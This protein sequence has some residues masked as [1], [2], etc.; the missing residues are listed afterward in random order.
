MRSG[1]SGTN[2]RPPFEI[3]YVVA[4]AGSTADNSWYSQ[5]DPDT[6]SNSDY[7]N[8]ISDMEPSVEMEIGGD[9]VEIYTFNSG[10]SALDQNTF[11]STYAP[12][13]TATLD[14]TY[15][16]GRKVKFSINVSSET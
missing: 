9:W 6:S 5:I 11:G 12:Y 10:T 8:C 15:T 1:N 4:N 16:T 13:L 3:N 2:N 14:G 7:S